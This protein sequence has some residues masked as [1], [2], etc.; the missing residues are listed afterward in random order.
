M[1]PI[2][3]KFAIFGLVAAGL[4]CP[5]G[6]ARAELLRPGQSISVNQPFH[7]DGNLY[8]MTLQND[9]NL[10][11]RRKDGKA[12]W[13]TGTAGMGAVIATMQADGN[14]VMYTADRRAIWHTRTHG[15]HR[16]FGIDHAGRVVVVM[17][18]KWGNLDLYLKGETIGQLISAAGG[19]FEWKTPPNGYGH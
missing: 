4:T 1:N 19:V 13:A 10:V 9:G 18:G 16:R 3:L 12:I 2:F 14:F 17:P 7:S 8:T 11:L 6:T 5:G 15:P